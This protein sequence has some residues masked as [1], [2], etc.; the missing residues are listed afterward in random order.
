MN[1]ALKSRWLEALRSGDYE[2]GTGY[3]NKKVDGDHHFCC[4]GVLCDLVEPEAW[5]ESDLED[6]MSHRNGVWYGLPDALFTKA[7]GLTD[8]EVSYLAALNDNEWTFAEIADEIE[9][10]FPGM[11]SVGWKNSTDVPFPPHKLKGVTDAP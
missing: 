5:V 10:G 1:D 6:I 8:S 7:R 9:A 3:L 2:Q 4:L 11:V